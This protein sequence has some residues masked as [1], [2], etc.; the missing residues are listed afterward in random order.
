MEGIAD[1]SQISAAAARPLLSGSGYGKLRRTVVIATA[2]V[3]LAPLVIMTFINYFQYERMLKDESI[4]GIHRLLAN[5]KQSLEFLLSE[6]RSALEYLVQERS[7]SE[8]CSSETLGLMIRHM[9]DSFPQSLFVDLGL[10]DSR[11]KQIHYHGPHDLEGRQYGTHDWFH[12]TIREGMFTSDVFLGF[13]NS[14]H[15]TIAT[16]HSKGSSDYYLL[17][18]TFDAEVLNRQIHKAGLSPRD[19]IFLMNRQG[20][21]QTPSRRYGRV[22]DKI[23]LDVPYGSSGVQVYL[24]E[25]ES[26]DS[27]FLGNT[28]IQDSP[29]ILMF[30]KPAKQAG[31]IWSF[32]VQL[33][34]FLLISSALIMLVILWGSS[35][36]V[37]SLRDENLRRASLMHKV[38]YSNKLAS[39]GRLAAGVAHEINNPLAIINE[40]AGLLQDLIEL[41][42]GI[43]RGEKFLGLVESI[44]A[45][46][47]RCKKITHRLLGFA[48]QMD[49]RHEIIDLAS[50][51]E[52]VRDFIGKEAEYRNIRF[53]LEKDENLPQIESDRG[54]LQQVFINLLNN[55][56]S[57][58]KEDGH[59]DIEIRNVES[60]W[61]SVSI[62]DDGIGISEKN[63]ERIFEPFFTTKE[64]TG[65]GLGLSITYG[66]VKKLGGKI[67][68][69]S[70]VGKGTRFTVLLPVVRGE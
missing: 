69:S 36:F 61:I 26:G 65:T 44:I 27:V 34:I 53:A 42:K 35:Q 15:F 11:G 56:F 39:I 1:D 48:R 66:I 16:R 63:L 52:E 10:I 50:L 62:S 3:S 70:E 22:L 41:Q 64:G 58:V 28:D 5:N 40:K 31:S 59:I 68:V 47:E 4:Q 49:V 25:D 20:V 24:D 29:F 45:S 12:R 55:A 60:K 57:A 14:P 46:V 21:L 17:R 37:R 7:Y 67:S 32:P 38:E 51:I 23:N 43:P 9:N 19:D 33:V 18:A 8:L 30:V 6:R 54:Q 13:R 2:F